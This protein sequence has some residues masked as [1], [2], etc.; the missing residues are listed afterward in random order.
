MSLSVSFSVSELDVTAQEEEA[1]QLF[2]LQQVHYQ[3]QQRDFF[4]HTE[5]QPSTLVYHHMEN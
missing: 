1:R 5:P 3:L 4:M 2:Q